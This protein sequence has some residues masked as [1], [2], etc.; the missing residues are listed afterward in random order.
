[1]ELF[2]VSKASQEET[3]T[4]EIEVAEMTVFGIFTTRDRADLIADKHDAGV[5]EFVADKEELET[6]ERWI[7]PGYIENG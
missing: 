5:T 1:M 7:N 3:R 4:G 6:V 2:L